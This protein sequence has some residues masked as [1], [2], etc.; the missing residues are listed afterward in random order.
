MRRTVRGLSAALLVMVSVPV[1]TTTPAYAETVSESAATAGYFFK[2]NKNKTTTDTQVGNLPIPVTQV[3][4]VAAGDLAVAVSTPEGSEKESF[5]YFDLATIEPDAVVNKATLTLTLSEADGSEQIAPDPVKVQGAEPD[6]SGFGDV[7][8]EDYAAKPAI[9]PD[10]LKAPAKASADGKSYEFDVTAFAAKWVTGENNGIAIIPATTSSPFQVVFAPKDQ[11]K[12]T[13]D[14]SP[15]AG[16][17]DLAEDVTD[18]VDDATGGAGTAEPDLGGGFD[19]GAPIDGGVVDGAP[20]DGGILPDVTGAEPPPQTAP[21]EPVAAAPARNVAAVGDP[22]ITP[23]MRFWIG[24]ILGALLLA[25]ISLILGDSRVA[26][27]ASSAQ[28]SRIGSALQERRRNG[29][30]TLGTVRSA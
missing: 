24:G 5:F 20:L 9:L 10:G 30:L 7:D 28:S 21:E 1:L 29:P 12:I 18:A 17:D 14:Y 19:A 13:V 26:P 25:F 3:D 15:G 4:N 11:A 27:A 8:A 22:S 2:A 16:E 6:D 23:D